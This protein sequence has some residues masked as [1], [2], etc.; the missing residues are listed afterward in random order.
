MSVSL[1]SDYMNAR[2]GG[3]KRRYSSR[4]PLS[5]SPP[6]RRFFIL[7]HLITKRGTGVSFFRGR[8]RFFLMINNRET[9]AVVAM[10]FSLKRE[11]RKI[12]CPLF[13][14][15]FRSFSLS[16]IFLLH[17]HTYIIYY[18]YTYIIYIIYTHTLCLVCHTLNETS[19]RRNPPTAG[20]VRGMAAKKKKTP[21]SEIQR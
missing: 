4:R 9:L 2:R 13:F 11:F 12:Q 1:S 19:D 21:V 6:S 8:S 20:E 17:M 10:E 18:I 5:F 14:F 7:P 3:R 16:L 15:F